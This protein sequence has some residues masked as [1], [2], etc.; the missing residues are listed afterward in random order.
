MNKQSF[1]AFLK[2]NFIVP[3]AYSH[4]SVPHHVRLLIFLPAGSF[5]DSTII[6]DILWRLSVWFEG[7]NISGY[8]TCIQSTDRSYVLR[9][10]GS[11]SRPSQTQDW[12]FY[13][14]WCHY[15][16]ISSS[17]WCDGIMWPLHA[18]QLLWCVLQCVLTQ[19]YFLFQMDFKF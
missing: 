8:P 15:L 9:H 2:M 12:D 19:T 17:Q 5:F 14:A 11:V 3:F 10:L 16:C 1:T 6:K 13:R 7:W 4:H 18:V